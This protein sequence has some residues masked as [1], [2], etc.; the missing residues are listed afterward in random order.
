[1]YAILLIRTW[2]RIICRYKHRI[3]ICMKYIYI[4][5]MTRVGICMFRINYSVQRDYKRQECA[6]LIVQN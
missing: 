4:Y 3:Y 1:M 2:G 5:I 6:V